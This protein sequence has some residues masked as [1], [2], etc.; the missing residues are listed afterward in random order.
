MGPRSFLLA[1][2]EEHQVLG[3]VGAQPAG[4]E[5]LSNPE[6]KWSVGSLKKKFS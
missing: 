2:T 3:G 1:E 5:G 6:D 4:E